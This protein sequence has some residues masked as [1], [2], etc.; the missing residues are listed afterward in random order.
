MSQIM[1]GHDADRFASIGVHA[2]V[3]EAVE[4]HPKYLLPLVRV[5]EVARP[6]EVLRNDGMRE[7]HIHSI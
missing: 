6:M 2:W 3:A 7:H 1:L 5:D 4:H